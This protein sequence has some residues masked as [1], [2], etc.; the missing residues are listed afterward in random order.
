M[1]TKNFDRLFVPLSS[2]PYLWFKSGRKKWELRKYGRQYTDKYVYVGRL[3]E[4]RR[5]YSDGKQALWGI[6]EQIEY[7]Q[8]LSDFFNKVDFSE[9]IPVAL[10][11]EDAI[12]Q[13]ALLLRI[14]PREPQRMIGFKV[15]ISESNFNIHS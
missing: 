4:L 2:Q 7:A 6:I 11:L 12:S 3:V 8:D 15:K 13:T 14:H 1:A 9:V 5:G 10:S